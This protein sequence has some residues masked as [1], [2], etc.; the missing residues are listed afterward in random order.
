MAKFHI[1]RAYIESYD[2]EESQIIVHIKDGV[3]HILAGVVELT[4]HK[5]W[6][7]MQTAENGDLIINNSAGM[8]GNK[9]DHITKEIIGEYNGE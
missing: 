4:H 1:E 7:H 5:A 8:E 2:G 3:D 9:W 6:I